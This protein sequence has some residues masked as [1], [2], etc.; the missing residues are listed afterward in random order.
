MSRL[1]L[2]GLV[3]SERGK[4][5][6][7]R[8]GRARDV[9]MLE[10]VEAMDGTVKPVTCVDTAG[11]CSHGTRLPAQEILDRAQDAID[12]YLG[13]RTLK[14]IG[15]MNKMDGRNVY[16][17]YNAT[18]PLMPEVKADMVERP[19]RLRQRVEHARGRPEG[20]VPHRRRP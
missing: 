16:M 19:R 2:S 5:G 17:D 9:T 3:E 12:A 4:N 13:E 14:D 1:K 20:A 18:T 10:I 6:G 7:Y 8:M 11:S 15:R